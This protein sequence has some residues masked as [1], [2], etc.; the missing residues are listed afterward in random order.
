MAVNENSPRG[1]LDFYRRRYPAVVWWIK[2]NQAHSL[3]VQQLA[4]Q[5]PEVVFVDAHPGLDGDHDKFI[6]L[7]HFTQAGRQ[8]LA[9][10]IFAGIKEP[11]A[12][13]FAAPVQADD[14]AAVH[15][16]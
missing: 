5:H 13:E 1:V 3:I 12:R 11:L 9:E 10:T 2:A 14:P 4:Q 16:R 15:T 7:M 8:Q 6:D